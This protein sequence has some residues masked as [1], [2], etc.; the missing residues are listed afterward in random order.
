[1][2]S[3]KEIYSLPEGEILDTLKSSYQGISEEEAKKRLEEF[4]LNEIK[5]IRQTPLILKFLANFYHLFAILLWVGGILAFVGR[6]P[7]LGWAIFAVIV[8]NAVFSFWQEYKAEKATEALKKML[9]SYAKVIRQGELKKIL[10]NELVPGDLVILE[11]GD[12]I[13]ADGRLIEEI[14]MRVNQATLTGESLAV[15]KS[16]EIPHTDINPIESPNLIF[17][18]T[19]VAAGTGKAI[20]YATGMKTEFGKIAN[21]TQTV[22]DELSPLQKEMGRVTQ[23]V[24]VLAIGL[25]I[26]FFVL[27]SIRG[28]SF[29]QR[30]LFSIGIIVANVPEGLLPTITLSLAMGV[31]RMAKRHALVKK[32]SSVETLGSTTVICTDKTGT[33]TQNEMTVRELF[34]N[35]KRYDLTGVG[36]IPEGAILYKDEI[37][38]RKDIDKDLGNLLRAIILCN[39]AKLTESD[40]GEGWKIIGDPTEGALLVAAEKGDIFIE[41]TLNEFPRI[42]QLPFDSKRKMMSTINEV[43]NKKYAYVK[44]APKEIIALCN[45]WKSH[46]E[47]NNLTDDIQQQFIKANDDFAKVGL[48]V[49]AIAERKLEKDHN[50]YRIETV[51]QELTLLGLVAMMDPPRPEVQAAVEMCRTAGIK[52]VM[53]TGDYGLTAESIA[54]K[55]GIISGKNLRV[56][57]GYEIENISESELR[58]V[59]TEEN[60]IFARVSPEHKMRVVSTL[61]DLNHTVA[62]TGDGVND[63]PALKRA[64]IGVAMGITG[65]DVAKEAAEMV[66]TDDNFASIVSAIEEGRAVY[67]NIRKFVT[68]IFAS[69]IPEIIP[70]ILMVMF[71]IPLPLTILQILAVDLGT[72][73][74]PALSL[75]I[76][77]PEPGIM[78]QPPRS[79]KERLLNF[80]VLSRAYFFLGPIEAFV[81]MAGFF[82]TYIIAGYAIPEIVGMP[83][84]G[85]LYQKATT[86]TLAGIVAVQIGNGFAVRS[87]RMSIFKV[88]FFTNRLYLTGIVT[89]VVL[90]FILVYFTPLQ[91]VFSLQ[92][93]GFY[94][95]LFL[96][97]FAPL[98]LFAE[99]IRKLFVR[100]FYN[101]NRR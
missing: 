38:G 94:D 15:R 4:G 6:L 60:I 97:S 86:M 88:G 56:I 98:I 90:I 93:L 92:P 87:E 96:F 21:L 48:R 20:V 25:G 37:L 101:K 5:E 29:M 9:P 36:Y 17:A 64:D 62:V 72:D 11:E 57:S 78:N 40:N 35:G 18:G 59:L 27:G 52:I 8:I 39:N 7:E 61:K 73:M 47:I 67:N 80:K 50:N 3:I 85:T 68:Y 46:G 55:I 82:F 31:Q 33:L 65:S 70:F 10:A 76:E 12:N 41:K 99:E 100:K 1:M 32:L 42:Y 16:T 51:E 71:D 19:S 89:E 74:L 34:A 91:K 14:E 23:I 26:I 49:L 77:K 95:W 69:N 81:C 13:S 24:A 63:A 54:R 43:N 83:D 53:I 75:G 66:L 30:F 79:R 22:V 44:G 28:M 58:K 2:K 45:K 84:T